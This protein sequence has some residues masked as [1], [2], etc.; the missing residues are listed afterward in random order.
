MRVSIV[1]TGYVGLVSG[2]CLASKGHDVTCVD[3]DVSKIRQIMDGVPPIHE[4]G[5]EELLKENVGV[6][7]RASTDLEAAVLDSDITLIAVGTPFDGQVIDLGYV[8]EASRQIG[9]ALRRKTGFH[10][11]VVKSTVVPGTTEDVVAPIVAEASGKTLGDGFGVG[12]NPEFLAEGRAVED[13]MKPDRIVLGAGD[14]R[15]LRLLEELYDVFPDGDK[16]RTT[17]RTAEMI[18]YAANSLLATMIS[19]ANEIAG[20]CAA[21]TDVDVV[22][23]LSGVHLDKRLSPILEDGR[24]V[25]APLTTYVEA[26]CGFGGSCFPKDVKA[27]VAH[28]TRSGVDMRLLES[29]LAINANQPQRMIDLLVERIPDLEGV[30]VAVLGLAFKPGTDD[31]RESP[32]LS[33]VESLARLGASVRLYDPIVGPADF[34]IADGASVTHAESLAEA[35]EGSRAALL[36]TR[37]PEF[38][39]VPSLIAALEDP[40][41]LVDGRRM[42]APDSVPEYAGIGLRRSPA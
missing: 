7:L 42:L 40:P 37:W 27:L 23:V 1:G 30:E 19:F 20:L 5:L 31:T 28:G 17:P 11:V 4:A 26:G 10:A 15:T 38:D 8:R 14:P 25:T 24:R 18:K 29:V 3:V 21:H 22:D 34:P 39:A 2:V 36:V 41:L 6:R 16:V 32:A 33:I 13:F 12:M 9:E 35:L